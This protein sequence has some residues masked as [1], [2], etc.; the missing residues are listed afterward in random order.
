MV[1]AVARLDYLLS[2]FRFF[3]WK[4]LCEAEQTTT[5][6]RKREKRT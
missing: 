5:G 4:I 3:F 1:I 2:F 6:S